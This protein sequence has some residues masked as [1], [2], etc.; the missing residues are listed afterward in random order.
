[1]TLS[2][3]IL[4]C[5]EMCPM[6]CFDEHINFGV[7]MHSCIEWILILLQQHFILGL[8]SMVIL[9]REWEVGIVYNHYAPSPLTLQPKGQSS[10]IVNMG[11]DMHLSPPSNNQVHKAQQFP[12]PCSTMKCMSSILWPLC[13]WI[14]DFLLHKDLCNKQKRQTWKL[15]PNIYKDV[16]KTHQ[17]RM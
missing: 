14:H 16:N 17:G 4:S 5:L 2:L 15:L 12:F 6:Q 8:L 7:P 13:W 9:Y 1:M 10:C 11:K 3:K